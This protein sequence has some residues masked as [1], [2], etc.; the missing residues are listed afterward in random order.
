MDSHINQ[1]IQDEDGT[2]NI[3]EIKVSY[4]VTVCNE[5]EEIQRL[6]PHLLKHKRPQDEIVVLWDDNG[7][8]RVHEYLLS[9]NLNTFK[10]LHE[11][12]RHHFAEWKNSLTKECTGNFIFQ[13][14]ADEIPNEGLMKMIHW[15]IHSNKEIDVFLV[16]RENFVIGI[17]DEYIQQC[18]WIKDEFDRINYPDF[19]WRIYRNS[20]SIK[21]INKVHERLDGFKTYTYLPTVREYGLN[22][23]K[24][25]EKQQKQNAYYNTL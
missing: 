10:Y 17:T 18:R 15:L 7:D 25:F 9:F 22:H 21:W 23:T 16:P 5:L 6:I 1:Y 13:I 12:F 11:S 20:E 4:A 2:I 14:D 8:K 19:Q 3:P 24:T